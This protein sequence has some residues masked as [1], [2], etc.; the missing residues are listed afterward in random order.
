MDHTGLN[1]IIDLQ[2]SMISILTLSGA[3]G[4]PESLGE[5]HSAKSIGEDEDDIESSMSGGRVGY[6]RRT[7]TRKW[8]W[9]RLLLPRHLRLRRA[10]CF[11]Q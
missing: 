2:S 8:F 6:F 7:V 1:L 3:A 9:P 4:S 11:S 5:P 10:L